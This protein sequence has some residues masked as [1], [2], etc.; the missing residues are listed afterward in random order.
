L[1]G[2]QDL[3]KHSQFKGNKRWTWMQIREGRQITSV[4]EYILTIGIEDFRKLQLKTTKSF[5]R[6]HRMV[7]AKV[8]LQ[9][10]SEHV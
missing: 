1:S 7:M 10:E 9:K 6:N 3:Q 8:Y 2:L 5:D 4:C